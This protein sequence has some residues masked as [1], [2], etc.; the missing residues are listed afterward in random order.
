MA[1][2]NADKSRP[3][4][5]AA[6]SPAPAPAPVS[7]PAPKAA[8][9]QHSGW[10]IQVGAFE[11]E[12]EAKSRLDQ[13]VA[14]AKSVLGKA[15]PFTEPVSKGDKKYYRARFAGLEKTQAENACRYL[16]RN[17]IACITIKN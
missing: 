1:S 14:R 2:A 16:K 4:Q 11:D 12:G 7:A 15:D 5:V 13:A 3:V 9:I 10:I 17:D 8:P 6:A